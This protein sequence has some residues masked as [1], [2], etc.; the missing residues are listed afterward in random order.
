MKHALSALALLL[1]LCACNG[2]DTTPAATAP[3]NSVFVISPYRHQGTWVFDDT[4]AG[5]EKEPFVAGIPEM[6]DDLAKDIPDADKGFRLLF[7]AKP[8]PGHAVRL[9]WRREESGGNWY[10]CEAFD[11]EGWLCPALFKYFKEAPKEIYG[12][13]EPN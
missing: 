6:V 7:S 9:E 10:Y 5:L 4:R 1:L 12:K 13:A 2:D 3:E 11:K 8:F